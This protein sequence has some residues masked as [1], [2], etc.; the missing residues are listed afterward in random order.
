MRKS[1]CQSPSE[2][3][4]IC[5]IGAG[6]SGLRCADTLIQNGFRVTILEAR[7]R[8]FG[9]AHQARLPSGPLIDLGPNWVHG[10]DHNPILD[11]AKETGTT[12]YSVRSLTVEVSLKHLISLSICTIM[13]NNCLLVGGTWQFIR[14]RRQI[15]KRCRHS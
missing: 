7:D 12:L 14:R 10:T 4:K 3:P 5:I 2:I 1:R 9:R 8:L 6:I 13:A 11:L 15:T